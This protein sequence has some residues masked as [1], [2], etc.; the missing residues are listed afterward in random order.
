MG[1]G[2]S[3]ITLPYHR[4]PAP[5]DWTEVGSRHARHTNSAD[6]SSRD[7]PSGG[8]DRNRVVSFDF[9][10]TEKIDGGLQKS[11]SARVHM[12]P[13]NRTMIDPRSALA[14]GQ[15]HL[16]FVIVNANDRTS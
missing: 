2:R 5:I 15:K 16:R 4:L 1:V 10:V 3:P 13:A 7:V 9:Y 6:N 8:K 11:P 14:A 12:L